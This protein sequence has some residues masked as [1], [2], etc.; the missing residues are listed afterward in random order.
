MKS[1]F[2][3]QF[4]L[5]LISLDNFQFS[6]ETTKLTEIHRAVSGLKQETQTHI[7]DLSNVHSLH[8]KNVYSNPAIQ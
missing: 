5:K 3:G 7:H 4:K 8:A 2:S 6:P 1:D